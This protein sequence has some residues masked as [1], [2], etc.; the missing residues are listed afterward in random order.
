MEILKIL[1]DN[2]ESN[3]NI[4]NSPKSPL[5]SFYNLYSPYKLH[6]IQ[7]AQATISNIDINERLPIQILLVN[8]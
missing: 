5:L 8:K 3:F 6:S 1:D 2:K 4:T 7:M